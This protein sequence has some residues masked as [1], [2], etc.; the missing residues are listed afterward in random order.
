MSRDAQRGETADATLGCLATSGSVLITCS[1]LFFNA[2]IVMALLNALEP[3]FPV[4]AQK[5]A[6]LQ[7]LLF[8]TPVVMVVAEWMAIDFARNRFFRKLR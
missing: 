6:T 1:L 8:A 7:F 4:W 2:S 5:P 3:L